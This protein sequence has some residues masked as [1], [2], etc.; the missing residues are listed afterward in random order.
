MSVVRPTWPHDPNAIARAVLAE[1]AF[2]AGPRSSAAA[3]APSLLEA[4]WQ[5]FLDHV[6]RPLF[7]PLV[8][9]LTGSHAAVPVGWALIALSLGVFALAL[10]RLALA[11]VRSAP[12]RGGALESASPL[13]ESRSAEEWLATAR[14]AARRGDFA[15]AI[16]A[17]FAAALARLDERGIVTLDP[18]RTPGEYGRLVRRTCGPAAPAFEELAGHFVRAAYARATAGRDDF[19]AAERAFLAFEPAA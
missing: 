5:W 14:E 15:R 1:P 2:H 10:V 4:L 9:A 11:F 18:A 7:H 3:P 6:L 13:A 16:A 17:L 8:N 12:A 19:E